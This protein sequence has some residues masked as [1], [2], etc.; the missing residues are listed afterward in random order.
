VP[1]TTVNYRYGNDNYV[2]YMYDSEGNEK[3]Y[4]T[5]YPARWDRIERLVKAIS[6][7]LMAPVP[8]EQP[9]TGNGPVQNG[10]MPGGPNPNGPNPNGHAPNNGNPGTQH[11]Y[12]GGY[13]IPIEVPPYTVI[14]EDD[15]EFDDLPPTNNQH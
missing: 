5:N 7:D 14:E 8:G 3:F 1:Y 2:L 15:D 12:R 11:D 6:N 10:P 9:P 4:A 13:R